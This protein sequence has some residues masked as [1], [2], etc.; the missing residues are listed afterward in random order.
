MRGFALLPTRTAHEQLRRNFPAVDWQARVGSIAEVSGAVSSGGVLFERTDVV[1]VA[2]A[3]PSGI[4]T[5]DGSSHL[6]RFVAN[7]L[8]PSAATVPATPVVVVRTDVDATAA[9]IA[10][11]RHAVGADRDQVPLTVAGDDMNDLHQH[12]A[13]V[14]PGYQGHPAPVNRFIMD[15]AVGDLAAHRRAPVMTFTSAKG[16]SGKTTTTLMFAFAASH[17]AARRGSRMN[18]VIVELDLTGAVA[19]SLVT[20][21]RP[22]G[23]QKTIIDYVNAAEATEGALADAL[24]EI[25]AV[26]ASGTPLLSPGSIRILLGPRRTMDAPNVDP[27]H[28]A[29]ILTLLRRDPDV[30]LVLVDTSA[31]VIE[32]PV[33]AE[34]FAQS[35][36]LLYVIEDK[37]TSY[38]KM[39][40][41]LTWLQTAM[42][43]APE[44]MRVV[45]NKAS[46][47]VADQS[48]RDDLV[49]H[50]AGVPALGVIPQSAFLHGFDGAEAGSMWAAFF[51]PGEEPLGE[52]FRSLVVALLPATSSSSVMPERSLRAG[53]APTP[54]RRAGWLARR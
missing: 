26:D 17:L 40:E 45:V 8:R 7:L 1:I 12:L 27:R 32:S 34:A 49:A 41:T 43:V 50:A 52:A 14:V 42:G 6:V 16:G 44:R 30:D 5:D 29:D 15:V 9:L 23:D 10:Q 28:V 19:R 48:L 11:I 24:E 33:L 22:A 13:Q 51:L 3:M 31:D 20:T 53:G 21:S 38:A 35:D 54:R 39:D 4:I 2:D 37:P 46:R 25:V 18:V 36:Q 47:T